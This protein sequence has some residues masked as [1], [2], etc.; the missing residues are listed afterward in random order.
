MSN[1]RQF[2]VPSNYDI[3][4]EVYPAEEV[5][6][7]RKYPMDEVLSAKQYDKL[8]TKTLDGEAYMVQES[9]ADRLRRRAKFR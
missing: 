4:L 3:T 7:K 1:S 8:H 9:Y 6:H 5:V 2:L